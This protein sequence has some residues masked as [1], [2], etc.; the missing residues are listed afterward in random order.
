MIDRLSELRALAAKPPEVVEYSLEGNRDEDVSI[1]QIF[2]GEEDMECIHKEVQGTRK[3][4]LLL[5]MDVKRLGKESSRFLTSVRRFSSIK[6]DANAL[7]RGIK[8]RGEALFTRLERL[9]RLSEE[10][11]RVHG[12]S[13]AVARVARCQ[14]AALTGSFHLAMTEYN[15]AEMEQRENCTARIQRQAAIVGKEV[16]RGQIEELMETGKWD[17]FVGDGLLTTAGARSA[18]SALS[19][20]ESRRRE[21]LELEGRI[22]D[23]RDL[24]FQVALLAEE[25]GCMVDHIEDHVRGAQDYVAAA[26]NHVRQAIKYKKAN[27]CKK[28]FCCCFPCCH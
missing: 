14:L 17:A 22:R 28:I 9:S 20:I 3:E 24:F 12:D 7:G 21:L 2:A 23:M 27:P 18:R 13:S 1:M 15:R 8:T 11:A 25:Q 16:T 26:G 19:E 10:L 5:T 4:I 6:R